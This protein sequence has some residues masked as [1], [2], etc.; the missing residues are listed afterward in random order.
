MEHL[1]RPWGPPG[2][3]RPHDLRQVLY[4]ATLTLCNTLP[5]GRALK[6]R[7]LLDFIQGFASLNEPNAIVRG[8]CNFPGSVS[9]QQKFEAMDGPVLQFSFIM[10]NK[11]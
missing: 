8:V 7:F 10:K 11:G 2:I 4:R 6:E 1:E 3:Y 9:L 5:L